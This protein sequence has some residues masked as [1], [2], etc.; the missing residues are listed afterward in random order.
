MI[1]KSGYR[2]SEKIMLNKKIERD[3]D[4]SHMSRQFKL[5]YGL[6]PARWAAMLV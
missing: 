1:Q 2:F 3:V 4:Q 5:A 6:T